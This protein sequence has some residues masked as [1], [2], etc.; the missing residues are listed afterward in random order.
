VPDEAR[1]PFSREARALS[2][3]LEQIARAAGT[4]VS[5]ASRAL[6]NSKYAVSDSTR[7]RIVQ[8]AKDMGYS[9]NLAARGLR[10]KTTNV[11]GIVV[12]NVSDP[13]TSQIV[14]GIIDELKLAG[15]S[16]IIVN[17]DY[18]PVAERD[19]VQTLV[20]NRTDGIIFVHASVHSDQSLTDLANNQPYVSIARI[21]PPG[22]NMVGLDDYYGAQ[23]AVDH[24][25]KSGR[26][27]IAFIGGPEHWW[28]TRERLAGYLDSLKLRNK[29]APHAY[30]KHGDWEAE[31]G[32]IAAQEL[33]ALSPR[34]DAIF[35]ANDLMAQGAIYAI[36]DAGLQVPGDI[37]VV[38]HDDREFAQVVRPALTT[39]RLPCYE[40]GQ[41]AVQMIR[42]RL[43]S[44][45]PVPAFLVRG[46]LIVRDS[47]GGV[48]PGPAVGRSETR[49]G[50][51][52][53]AL[54][55]AGNL[56]RRPLPL[57]D[58]RI[59]GF[60]GERQA[61]DRAVVLPAIHDQL[62]K[63][64][65]IGA[66]R[67]TW[68]PGMPDAPRPSTEADLAR[69]IEA[70]C[71]TL[72]SHPDPELTRQVD[73]LVDLFVRAQQP[74]GYIN[75]YYTVVEP[76]RR[77]TDLRD[78][79]ELSSAGHILEAAMAHHEATG[80]FRFLNVAL[81]YID[82][83]GSLLG[84][85]EYQKHGYPGYPGIEMALVDH[86]RSTGERR[87]LELSRYFVHQRGLQPSYFDQEARDRGETVTD[88][89]R[90]RWLQ[91]HVP[92]WQ[93]TTAVGHAG[94]A[95]NLY[96]A[97]TDVGIEADDATMVH[98]AQKLFESVCYRRMYVTGGIGSSRETG[99]FTVDFDLPNAT[100]DAS[101][102]AAIGLFEWL[103]R[104]SDIDGDGRYAD[105]MERVLYNGILVGMSLDGRRFAD[106]NVL[107]V[108][109]SNTSLGIGEVDRHA[110]V[111]PE[112]G[113]AFLSRL[114][115]SLG[116]FVY[117]EGDGEI[118]IHH[119]LESST[120]VH[121]RAQDISVTQD[122]AY[123]WDGT[124]RIGIGLPKPASL[125]LKLRV[126]GWCQDHTVGV[127]GDAVDA[128][129]ER[130][131]LRISR[132]WRDGDVVV[133][134]MATPVQ[135]IYADPNVV[136]DRGRVALQRGPVL[137]CLEEVDNGSTLDSILLP[138]DAPI[139]ASFA[140]DLLGGV[141]TLRATGSREGSDAGDG[142]HPAYSTDAPPVRDFTITAV[143]YFAWGNRT[144][145]DMQVW[146]RESR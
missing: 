62:E 84:S 10:G 78:K 122:T 37:A 61:L 22:D 66:L 21:Q 1:T 19:A 5:T 92:P 141:V 134:E 55:P 87:Y 107:K 100:A 76:G 48:G 118:V 121:G 142:S 133:L 63:T 120:T 130:G 41:A 113:A 12:E 131:Y 94:R 16:S 54:R 15:Y 111:I 82:L 70:A 73:D 105:I 124:V 30:I 23:L 26:E 81:R 4:S 136:A 71:L 132:T 95:V 46:E 14:R 59:G 3:T 85:G 24:L 65:V 68:K 47:C 88:P 112:P 144:S 27:R 20:S 109:R 72:A 83:I 89:E 102:A 97:M 123:P 13:F 39:V 56:K 64:G 53:V 35:A 119:Y 96:G 45:E 114:V 42:K 135:R 33:L 98:A 108:Q 77:F 138:R 40:M 60:W 34:P 74:D 140:D 52:A 32:R 31:S 38:G 127:N 128:A 29:P 8:L 58:V 116:R 7:Q 110:L 17:T 9:P 115:A 36:Q 99:G 2:T 104:M 143:P 139:A 57:K 80:E 126:P 69:W 90:S 125:T 28:S 145:G 117:S 49:V 101:T 25:L 137:F 79:G 6:H 86:Y 75:A 93:Q 50:R 67:L 106:A 11:V 44:D 91:A 43:E 18:D 51:D 129:V 146:I 103:H